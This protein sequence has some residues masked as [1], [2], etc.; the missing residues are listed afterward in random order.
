MLDEASSHHAAR[1][2]PAPP[3]GAGGGG[4]PSRAGA[5]IGRPSTLWR[6]A[7]LYAEL[8]KESMVL[9][10]EGCWE[11]AEWDVEPS[12]SVTQL[13]KLDT[14]PEVRQQGHTLSPGAVQQQ[15]ERGGH[16]RYG[17]GT[18]RV[19]DPSVWVQIALR[20]YLLTQGYKQSSWP[21]CLV[22][23]ALKC[24]LKQDLVVFTWN[25]SFK[26]GVQVTWDQ[27]MGPT[28]WN[29]QQTK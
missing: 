22:Q 9:H 12:T 25:L 20:C 27:Q 26:F 5:Q 14:H 7:H 11:T 10:R 13:W 17:P 21:K 1:P 24:D 18:N 3:P 23:I 2:P 19:I 8:P 29:H 28:T 15:L 4:T 6:I 16:H